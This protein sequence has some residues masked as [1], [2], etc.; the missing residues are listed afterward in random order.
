MPFSFFMI[1]GGLWLQDSF[2]QSSKDLP[3]VSIVT[4]TF[5]AQEFLAQA[6]DSIIN[7]SYPNVELI[8]IDGGSSDD[9]LS[10]IKAREA[11]IDFWISEPD[12]GIYDAMNKGLELARG[13]WIGF[14]NADD[15]YL[16]DAI[17]N[18]IIKSKEV[19]ADVFYGNS[20]SVIQASPL[21]LSPYF[22]NHLNLG[23]SPSIDHRS[24]FV[25]T[26]IHK[27]IKF[28]L[29]YKLAADFDVFMRLKSAGAVFKHM[30]CFVSYKRYGGASDGLQVLKESFEIN[31][32]YFGLAKALYFRYNSFL[33]YWKWQ[34][35]NKIL[36]IFLGERRYHEFKERK[37]KS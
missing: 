20:Y 23:Q 30:N 17:Q 37:L 22:T 16:D 1:F 24:L 9:T 36:K 6:L 34:T 35:G 27:K 8:V 26:E 15:W 25:R 13:E 4:V 14:K 29:Q 32:K 2:K 3:L 12:K 10:I 11:K 5:N 7:Q 31:R 18:L 21:K 19:Y 33:K 28:D